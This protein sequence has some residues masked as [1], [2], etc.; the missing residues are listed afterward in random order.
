MKH[1]IQLPLDQGFKQGKYLLEK[2]YRNLHAILA[3]YRKKV[4]D[5]P[6]KKFGMTKDLEDPTIFCLNAKM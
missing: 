3:S 4:K 6:Q 5:W 2:M 1:C